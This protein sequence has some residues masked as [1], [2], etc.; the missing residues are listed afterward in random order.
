MANIK[1]VTN[2]ELDFLRFQLTNISMQGIGSMCYKVF[3]KP[4]RRNRK[5]WSEAREFCRSQG[6]KNNMGNGDLVSLHS[7]KQEGAIHKLL[8][9]WVPGTLWIGLNDKNSERK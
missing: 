5:T 9:Y 6:G 2:M 7:Q 1:V 8:P 4:Y 3:V